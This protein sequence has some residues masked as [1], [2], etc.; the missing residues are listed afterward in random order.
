MEQNF[1]DAITVEDLAARAD[2]SVTHFRR[3][4]KQMYGISPLERLIDIRLNRAKDLIASNM[5]SIGEVALKVGYDS[6]YHFSRLFKKA[7]GETPSDFRKRR[8]LDQV[9]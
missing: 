7:T 4:F 6:I 1:A 2:L 3:L 5:F 9:K 8:L